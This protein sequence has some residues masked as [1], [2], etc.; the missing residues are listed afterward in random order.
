MGLSSGAGSRVRQC[1]RSSVG[2]TSTSTSVASDY[3]Q[4]ESRRRLPRQG[5]GLQQPAYHSEE[6]GAGTLSSKGAASP[7][8]GVDEWRIDV[9]GLQHKT[10][11][12]D[13][14]TNEHSLQPKTGN[15]RRSSLAVPW[16][17]DAPVEVN[18][19]I[20]GELASGLYKRIRRLSQPNIANLPAPPSPPQGQH[21]GSVASSPSNSVHK[22]SITKQ[23]R[24]MSV[25]DGPPSESMSIPPSTPVPRRLSCIAEE[26]QMHDS[27]SKVIEPQNH[28]VD[29]GKDAWGSHC[30]T[31]RFAGATEG[32]VWP[33]AACY[34]PSTRP[35]VH[36]PRRSI[37]VVSTEREPVGSPPDGR[38]SE[39]FSLDSLG[40]V[41]S[42]IS[43]VNEGTRA[44]ILPEPKP[45]ASVVDP[46]DPRPA[47]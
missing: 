33:S 34:A 39:V 41:M 44:N 35:S 3:N 2:A 43:D 31:T 5:S 1:K 13:G 21:D 36:G 24:R 11:I 29:V 8:D 45:N 10:A 19:S 18:T 26:G 22:S 20:L 32:N 9:R 46:K 23:G 37:D 15:M 40:S 4:R 47:A 6:D 7:N 12:A 25:G 27:S 38:A 16:S 17:D 30:S 42:I 28:I 14:V